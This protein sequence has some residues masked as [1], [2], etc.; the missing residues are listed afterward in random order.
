MSDLNIKTS[1]TERSL[2]SRNLK[3]DKISV[4]SMSGQTAIS[5]KQL[6]NKNPKTG[7]II[8]Q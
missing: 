2:E 3:K 5:H 7:R 4:Q 8:P 1:E 6:P